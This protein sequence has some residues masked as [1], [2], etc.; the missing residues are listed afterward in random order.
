LDEV[1]Q[2][3][4]G[5]ATAA[6]SFTWCGHEGV[7]PLMAY[8]PHGLP[9]HSDVNP[10]AASAMHIDILTDI[11]NHEVNFYT[12][13]PSDSLLSGCDSL[14]VWCL[15]DSAGQYLVFTTEG[16]LLSFNLQWANITV[17]SG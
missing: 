15:S 2:S 13:S 12:M 1:R 8:G 9:F 11:M 3:A 14:R 10:Y 4:W 17:T 16:T 7:S 5:C 6:A